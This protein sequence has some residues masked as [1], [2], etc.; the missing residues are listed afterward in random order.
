M[1]LETIRHLTKEFKTYLTI[2]DWYI[3]R[4]T[5][6]FLVPQAEWLPF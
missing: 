6:K 3:E 2:E 1:V 4:E 5:L